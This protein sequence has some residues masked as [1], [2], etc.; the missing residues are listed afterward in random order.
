MLGST[1]SRFKTE[2]CT[3]CGD[4]VEDALPCDFCG[5]MACQE[6]FRETWKTCPDCGKSGCKKHFDGM[7]C[8][9]CIQANDEDILEEARLMTEPEEKT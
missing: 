6:C 9:G 2:D 8:L 3:E 4:I 1:Y 7:Y 5:A